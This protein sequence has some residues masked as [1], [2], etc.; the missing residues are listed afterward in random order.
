MGMAISYSFCMKNSGRLMQL[1]DMQAIAIRDGITCI[2]RTALLHLP[3]S[4]C[5]LPSRWLTGRLV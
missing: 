2:L 1:G 3:C 4:T 5:A